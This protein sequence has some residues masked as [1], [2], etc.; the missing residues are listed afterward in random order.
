MDPYEFTGVHFF[1]SYCGCQVNLSDVEKLRN[2]IKFAVEASNA[3][4]LGQL[5]H[6]F[7]STDVV[8]ENGYTSVFILSESHA[9]I[10]TYPKK[11]SCFVDLFTCGEKCSYI[12][13]DKEL[14]NYLRPLSVSYQVIKRDNGIKVVE[15]TI[16]S[17]N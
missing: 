7:D 14:R 9:S 3:T 8:P 4:I 11:G 1:A 2:V 13:F 12:P 6:I 15:Q 10:H 5:E 16:Q 17:K